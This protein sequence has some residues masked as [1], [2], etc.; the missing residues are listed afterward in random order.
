MP[1]G[2]PMT[3]VCGLDSKAHTMGAFEEQAASFY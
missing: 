3:E 2:V 1:V